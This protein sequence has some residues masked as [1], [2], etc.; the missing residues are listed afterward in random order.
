MNARLELVRSRLERLRRYWQ[1][2]PLPR[3]LA[4][5]G[6]ELRQLLPE[7]LRTWLVPG[8]VWYLLQHQDNCYVLSRSGVP[9]PLGRWDDCM[10]ADAQQ[11][12]L[13]EATQETSGYDVRLALCLS[14]DVVLCRPMSLPLAARD[15][16]RQVA[17]FEMD[18]QTPFRVDQVYY[19]IR[20]VAGNAPTGRF[21]A[22]LVVVPR[23]ILDAQIERLKELGFLIDAVDLADH[24]TVRM[25]L[26]LLPREQRRVRYNPR[27]RLNLVLTTVCVILLG[28]SLNQWLR[29]REVALATMQA[30]V[31]GMQSQAQHVVLLRR[32]LRESANAGNFLAHRKSN[33]VTVIDVLKDLTVHLRADTWLRRFD[34]KNPTHISFQGQSA[35]AANLIENLQHSKWI[36]NPNFQGAIQRDSTTGKERFY[37]EAQVHVASSKVGIG[38]GTVRATSP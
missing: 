12:A 31:H 34:F 37:L 3:F 7:R 15:N 22:E 24:Q 20:E 16:L 17:A 36:F 4:W 1:D 38:A 2:S 30:R 11:L 32:Q 14:T 35:K 29:N 5:W 6:G 21:N 25:G 19:D 33:M 26:N 10:D 18:R 27:R 28:F 9:T 8:A 13:A 23:H